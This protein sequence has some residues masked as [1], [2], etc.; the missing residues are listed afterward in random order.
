MCLF[1]PFCPYNEKSKVGRWVSA[2][3]TFFLGGG[4]GGAKYKKGVKITKEGCEKLFN[5]YFLLNL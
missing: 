5:P 2:K 4:G 1:S 3:C